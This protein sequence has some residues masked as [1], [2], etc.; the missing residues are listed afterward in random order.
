MCWLAMMVMLLGAEEATSYQPTYNDEGWREAMPGYSFSFPRDHASHPDCRIEWWY[1]TGNL[2]SENGR[3]FGYQLTFF[4]TGITLEPKSASRWAVRDLYMT[5]FAISDGSA[6]RHH[7]HERLNRAGVGMAG[8]ATKHYRVW[9]EGW[10]VSLRGNTHHLVAEAEGDAIDLELTPLKSPALHGRDGISQKGAKAGNASHYYSLTRMETKG[11]VTVDG[12]TH[13]VRGL[14]W[15][16]HEFGTSFLE[17]EQIGWDWLSIQLD[18][19]W[20]L[21]L[22]QFRRSDGSSDP[23]TSGTLV[24]PEGEATPLGAG[25]FTMSPGETWTSSASGA[26]YPVSWKLSIPEQKAQLEVRAIFPQQEMRTP[27]STD[28]TYWEGA[29]D[30]SG[31]FGGASAGGSGYLEMTGYSGRPLGDS[32][33]SD[34]RVQ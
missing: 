8:A 30:V 18:N 25:D 10:Q 28:V 17:K 16:D 33:S 32:F 6:R 12:V 27:L 21:M 11:T 34:G 22:Y 14:S 13:R 26:R 20:E 2:V 19:D 1:Y 29:I 31:T 5:H 15:M 4:R 9:N 7:V 3:R 24:D 23:R